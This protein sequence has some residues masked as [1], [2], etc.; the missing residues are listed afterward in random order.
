[1]ERM[2]RIDKCIQRAGK[3]LFPPLCVLCRCAINDGYWCAGCRRDLKS[4]PVQCPRCAAPV[5][6]AGIP[7]GACQTS[8][9][10]FDSTLAACRYMAPVAQLI[11][12]LKYQGRLTQV[13]ALAQLLVDTAA[14]L[15]DP[16]EAL[17]P[18]P[19]H[20]RRLRHRGF[21]QALELA[22]VIGQELGIP[23]LAEA[24]IRSRHTPA[25]AELAASKRK[26]NVH[27]AFA[28][29]PGTRLPPNLA[30]VDDV[31]TTGSTANALAA[32]LRDAGS[33]RIQV[34]VVAR[35]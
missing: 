1:V 12:G 27:G 16:P 11:H 29:R 22:K 15:T 8:P 9:P 4:V 31:M 35:A 3:L 28:I 10:A 20:S 33:V 19:L 21:N 34:W 24:A 32:C 23:V 25:Q 17:V 13:P 7:C 2:P 6:V 14:G 5:E 18:V 26:R 30:V